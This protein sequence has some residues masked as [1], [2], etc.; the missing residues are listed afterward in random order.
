VLAHV[1]SKSNL[2]PAVADADIVGT[3]SNGIGSRIMAEHLHGMVEDCQRFSGEHDV[4]AAPGGV[5]AR[6]CV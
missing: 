2:D 6:C 5:S 1:S 4:D 3:A